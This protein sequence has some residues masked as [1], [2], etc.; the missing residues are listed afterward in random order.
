MKPVMTVG[1]L[2]EMLQGFDPDALVGV[3]VEE[4]ILLITGGTE[5]DGHVTLEAEL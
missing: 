3:M 5:D 1:D 2:V 4:D